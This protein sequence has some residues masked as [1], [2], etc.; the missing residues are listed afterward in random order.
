MVKD[1]LRSQVGIRR[2]ATGCNENGRVEKAWGDGEHGAGAV[3]QVMWLKF[4][5]PDLSTSS[6]SE[7][8]QKIEERRK[9]LTAR[10]TQTPGR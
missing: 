8:V 2:G 5:G 1:R 4:H 6:S 9:R 10:K 3:M 7:A